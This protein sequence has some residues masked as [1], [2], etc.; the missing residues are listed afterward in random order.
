MRTALKGVMLG[1][2]CC[3]H[4][5]A[6][7]NTPPV[8]APMTNRFVINGGNA[9]VVTNLAGD[10]DVPAQSLTYSLPV[11]PSG[12]TVNPLTGVVTWNTTTNAR[13]P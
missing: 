1:I 8:F 3:V 12:A 5:A 10:A 9:F 2:G 11:A 6:A 13:T 7:T 4:L